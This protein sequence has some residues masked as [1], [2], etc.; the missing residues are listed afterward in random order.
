MSET[1]ERAPTYGNA[2]GR[3]MCEQG[4]PWDHCG[5]P[6]GRSWDTGMATHGGMEAICCRCGATTEVGYV[7]EKVVPEGHGPHIATRERIYTWPKFW[8]DGARS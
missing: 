1:T 5:H 3:E 6:T 8:R 4:E 7:V 2:A